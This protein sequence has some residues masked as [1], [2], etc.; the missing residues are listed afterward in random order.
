MRSLGVPIEHLSLQ[1]D[2][3]TPLRRAAEIPEH[4][5]GAS[6]ANGGVNYRHRELRH[7][8][9]RCCQDQLVEESTSFLQGQQDCQGQRRGAVTTRV[10]AEGG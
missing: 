8:R 5:I 9:L 2:F 10:G 6:T 1:H 7:F 3:L 4:F